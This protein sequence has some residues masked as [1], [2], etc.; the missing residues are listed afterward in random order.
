MY[1]IKMLRE[2][3]VI[4]FA[5]TEL[6][7]YLRMMM[8][9]CGD[10]PIS[11]DH[12]ATEG[13]RLGLL[14]DFALP[15]EGEDAFLDDVVHID[16]DAQG[17]ILAGSNPRSVLFAVY[18]YLKLNGCRWLFAGLDGEYIPRK[19]IEPQKYHKL[20]DHRY[21]GHTTEGYPSFR[22]IME[23]I[24]FHPKLELNFYGL[25]DIHSYH[26]RYY[27]H[28]F[29]EANRAPE[30]VTASVID[31]YHALFQ[32][33]ILKRG[34]LISEGGHAMMAVSVGI[35]PADRAAIKSGKKPVPAKA[36]PY[37][38]QLKGKRA[39]HR[40][41]IYYTN[42][43]MSN[44]EWRNRYIQLLADYVEERQH[45]SFVR[46]PLG[47]L[48]HNHCECENCVKDGL[49]PSDF[50]VM[51][52][53][54]LD[55]ELTKRNIK[56]RITFSTYVD[57]MFAPVRERIKNQKRFIIQFTPISRSYTGSLS[58]NSV[59]PAP[60]EYRA[61]NDWDPP[62]SAEECV[63]HL[64]DWRKQFSGPCYWFEYHFWKAQYR[65]PGLM[66]IS[67]RL[68]EDNRS[69]KL[70]DIQ[71]ALQDGS[72][73]S[74][75]PHGFH[76]YIYAESL[77]N[78]DC[79]YEAEM[80]DY[81][82]HMYGD[83]WKKVAAYLKGISEA[84]GEK[85]MHGEDSAD[86]KKGGRYNPAR[87]AEL[88]AVGELAANARVLALKHRVTPNRPQ[89]VAYR[90]LERHAEYCEGVAEIMTAK[91]KGYD[92]QAM[93]MLMKFA[94]DFGKYDYE[95]DDHFDYNLAIYTIDSTLKEMPKIE[96]I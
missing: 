29:N 66:Y 30:P 52:L 56:T 89:T 96:A 76:H 50:Y 37:L 59:V 23:Y 81:F 12:Q 18:R 54:G 44:E 24:D 41:D 5:A 68:Y 6:K 84:F 70:F 83:D 34:L 82:S 1:Q 61:R 55:E 36:I 2:D 85:Y 31:Q 3:Q 64:L 95:L 21:R 67:R 17:G 20:A 92:K 38:A 33:E 93:E 28:Q 15:F 43:C 22:Q 8:P 51:I 90:M 74:F 86:R 65:D 71:G 27:N 25:I 19:G 42:M 7:K 47:D 75:F 16:T 77:W 60:K 14:E 87:A 94:E 88:D 78:R 58:E 46:A 9:E 45:L 72:N 57:A 91:C 48:S 49:R 32:T 79:D 40:N 63:A 13:F 35:D 4:N 69:M 11:C 73:K 26:Y 53:N 10:I 62:K 39:L 80:D